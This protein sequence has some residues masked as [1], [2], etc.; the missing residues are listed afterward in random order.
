M[1]AGWGRARRTPAIKV[2]D[3]RTF[4]CRTAIAVAL[5]LGLAVATEAQVP[6]PQIA[7]RQDLMK[8]N[9]AAVRRL[10]RM[11][12]GTEPW[13]LSAARQA[14]ATINGNS[15]QIISLFPPGTGADSG[16]KTG[17]RDTIWQNPSDFEAKARV[18]EDESAKL[19]AAGDDTAL[20]AQIPVVGK[21]C[22]GCHETYRNAPE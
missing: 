14:A 2:R 10:V 6:P 8:S 1:Q 7:Q 17:A 20:K 5:L 19:V 22:S 13:D 12:R 16:V 3:M 18:L 15:K 11:L 4:F 21:A 9:S